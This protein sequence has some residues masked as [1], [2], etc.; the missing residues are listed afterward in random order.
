LSA[1]GSNTNGSKSIDITGVT[2][3][4]ASTSYCVDVSRAT[5]DPITNPAAGEYSVTVTTKASAAVVDTAT[6]DADVISD[7]QIQV[8]ATVPASF[9]FAL[10]SN[11]TSFTTSLSTGSVVQTTQRTATINTN[12][13]S[14]WVAW[15]KDSQTGLH[16]TTASKTIAS[17]T[18]GSAATLSAGT[19]GYVLGVDS[20]N[21]G[22]TGSITVTA[23][24]QGTGANAD[25]SGL[26]TSY[27]QIASSNGT[28]LNHVL[29]LHGKAAINGQTPA[30][31]DYADTWTVIGA[32]SF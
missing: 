7:D 31:T 17:T 25:G 2:N 1:A 16:S 11:S 8:T 9:T 23:A 22:G 26:D 10:D 4:S 14:G 28:A 20:T 12:A 5:F 30:A 15:A 3:L 18:P 32:G 27:R 21:G 6:I 13:T 29:Q 19:E 24:Y